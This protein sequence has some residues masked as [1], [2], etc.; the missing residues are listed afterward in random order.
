MSATID[1]KVDYWT[2]EYAGP[3]V[4]TSA[5]AG[6]APDNPNQSAP[7]STVA[8][9]SPS[10]KPSPTSSPVSSISSAVSSLNSAST[11]AASN[12]PSFSTAANGGWSRQAY[13]N[14]EEKKSIGLTFLNHFGG[15]QGIPGTADGGSALVLCS[16]TRVMY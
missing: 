3:G 7:A 9:D 12:A 5:P 16:N 1:G 11:S 8:T 15:T 6:T 10:S 4:A 13:Y 14:A 2:N